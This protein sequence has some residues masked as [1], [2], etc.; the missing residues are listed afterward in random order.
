MADP[1]ALSAQHVVALRYR[2]A[3]SVAYG[4]RR[5]PRVKVPAQRWPRAARAA[6]FLAIKE[7]LA[8]L[9]AQ[10]DRLL[11]PELPSLLAL[12]QAN[13][14]SGVRLDSA[15]DLKDELDK[16]KAAAD[17]VLTAA[18]AKQLAQTA[19]QQVAA[20]NKAELNRQF[21]ASVGIELLH[22]EPYLQQQLALFADD[23]ARLITSLASDHLDQVSGIVMRAARAGT[24][25]EQVQEQI[26]E[27]FDV[28]E[29]KAEFLAR[30]QVGKLNGELTQLRQSSVGITEYEWSTS[31]DER[32]RARHA[33]LEGTTHSWDDPPVVDE[34]TGR[35]AHP[36][37][38]FQCRCTAIPK[39]DAILDALGDMGGGELPATPAPSKPPPARAPLVPEPAE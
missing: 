31:Q 6:Y 5:K 39:V 37:Q 23:N 7:L 24:R 21:R 17:P 32:V 10:I 25:V 9:H 15:D 16:I 38:D 36:G 22:G 34:K 35:R 8:G 13:K 4:K 30:D 27:R 14:P 3:L 2:R 19:G 28:T 11:I 12:V 26:S 20:F 18:R 33:E 29:S 1:V